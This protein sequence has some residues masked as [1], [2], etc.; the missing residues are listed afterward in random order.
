MLFFGPKSSTS[1]FSVLPQ[2][3]SQQFSS[4]LYRCILT[5]CAATRRTCWT[6]TGLG[7]SALHMVK[8]LQKHLKSSH[9]Y[10]DGPQKI[11]P[12]SESIDSRIQHLQRCDRSPSSRRT[13]RRTT[14]MCSLKLTRRRTTTRGPTNSL[15]SAWSLGSM[16]TSSKVWRLLNCWRA[17]LQ[18]LGM[19]WSAWRSTFDCTKEG[20]NE[21]DYITDESLIPEC[22]NFI[23]DIV[24]SED[25]CET[26]LGRPYSRT[27][28]S[29]WLRKS[30]WRTASTCYQKLPRRTMSST[31]SSR[32][33]LR[34]IE[35]QSLMTTSCTNPRIRW[36]L[37][38]STGGMCTMRQTPKTIPSCTSPKIRWR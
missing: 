7:F 18:S 19:S 23:K 37:E 6:F 29:A 25:S 22:L 36:R 13:P 9:R 10:I 34:K 8:K 11:T 14:S 2:T 1:C 35:R 5:C 26:F 16:G 33:V 27:K 4:V 38:V 28:S 30:S 3:V 32:R 21:I 12:D 24:N 20:Q 31:S 17:T 15:S